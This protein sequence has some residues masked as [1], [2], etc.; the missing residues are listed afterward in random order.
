MELTTYRTY[1]IWDKIEK[2]RQSSRNACV[3]YFSDLQ[4][5]TLIENEHGRHHQVSALPETGMLRFLAGGA[6][7]VVLK[8][9]FPG[10]RDG[11]RVPEV[12][13]GCGS[14]ALWQPAPSG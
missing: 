10:L 12:L 6:R 14:P 3:G 8:S 4:L 2:Y 9:L 7:F 13:T 5:V 1:E 11:E